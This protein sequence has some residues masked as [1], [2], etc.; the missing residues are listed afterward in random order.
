MKV[1][2]KDYRTIKFENKVVKIIDQTKLPHKFLL[3][4]LKTVNDAINLRVN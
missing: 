2:G 4:E 1:N 3:K